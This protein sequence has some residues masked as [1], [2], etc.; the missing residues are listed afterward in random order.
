MTEKHNIW[1]RAIA[2]LFLHSRIALIGASIATAAVIGGAFLM[3]M[4]TLF[5]V[6]SPY[7]GILAF[8]VF[9]AILVF[10]LLLRS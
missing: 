1:L 9:P 4:G 3:L 5:R 7:I 8:F 6:E 2:A 10:G